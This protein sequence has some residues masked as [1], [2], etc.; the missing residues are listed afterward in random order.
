MTSLSDY[1]LKKVIRAQ[2][3]EISEHLVY[4]WLSSKVKDKCNKEIL[5][6][7]S[8]D[9]LHHYNLW[10]NYTKKDVPPR[11]LW[12]YLYYFMARMFGITFALKLMERGEE[13][14]QKNYQQISKTIP[15]AK[16]M[17]K[18]ESKH[19]QKLLGLLEE[20]KLK[21]VGSIVLGLNDALVELTGA[22]A[23]LT[24]ALD[25]ARIVA[26][27]GS[28]TGIAASL[29]MAASG[30]Q[31]RRADNPQAK[32]TL[33][34]SLYTGATYLITVLLLVLPYLL[35]SNVL[36]SLI[37]TLTIAVIIIMMFT[38]YTS[39]AQNLKFGKRFLEMASISLGVAAIT[40]GI[41][42]LVKMWWGI[43]V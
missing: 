1:V 24:L 42:F 22:L 36:V 5:R 18:D 7:I 20:E 32:D 17:L 21:Y 23:G 3:K 27:T 8:D 38:F 13:G 4:S 35:L 29:S 25:N 33:K 31:S 11:R 10:K 9:E 37:C 6:N 30:F 41:G 16:V 26:I 28:I 12:V 15:E 2:R 43:Q 40:F 14:A 19:E 39:V 34:A